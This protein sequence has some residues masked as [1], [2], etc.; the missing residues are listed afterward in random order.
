MMWPTIARGRASVAGDGTPVGASQRT[1][2]SA[3]MAGKG[4]LPL[5][6][7][8]GSTGATGVPVNRADP[9]LLSQT[10]CQQIEA[11][12]WEADALSA[13]LAADD[14]TQFNRHAAELP[15]ALVPVRKELAVGH[16]WE[17]LLEPMEELGKAGPAK[18]LAQ[19]RA[20]FLPFSTAVVE[21]ARLLGK[22]APGVPALKIYHCPM[23]PK[24][25]LWVQVRGPLAN[26][27]YGKKMLKCG[28]EV[29]C[30]GTALASGDQ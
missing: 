24:P 30:G 7:A 2:P 20:R 17:K 25:G 6:D 23:A 16:H 27:F 3:G 18:D 9:T 29:G 14:L 19:A 4:G 5:T 15:G 10:Q 11:L 1:A 22:E 21:W 26:P 8:T 13:A 28:E 12:V